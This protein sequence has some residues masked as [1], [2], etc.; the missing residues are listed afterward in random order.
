MR[1]RRTPT[2]SRFRENLLEEHSNLPSRNRR[3]GGQIII[4]SYQPPTAQKSPKSKQEQWTS[5][6]QYNDENIDSMLYLSTPKPQSSMRKIRPKTPTRTLAYNSEVAT[7]YAAIQHNHP[8]YDHGSNSLFS[9]G[10]CCIQCVR[11]TEVGIVEN[12]GRFETLLDPGLHCIPWPLV[13]ISGRLSLVSDIVFTYLFPRLGSCAILLKELH[14]DK[15]GIIYC[16]HNINIYSLLSEYA[17]LMSLVKPRHLIMFFV[18][19]L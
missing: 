3:S 11:T 5:L 1:R 12:F 7:N 19:L 16:L 10:C 9:Y 13:D 2:S 4:S 6:S 14:S 15:Y 17:N 8:A 18:T